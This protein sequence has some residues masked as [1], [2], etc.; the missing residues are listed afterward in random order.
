MNL[1]SKILAILSR[2]TPPPNLAQMSTQIHTEY[3]G[4]QQEP[5]TFKQIKENRLHFYQTDSGNYT[6]LALNFV[7]LLIETFTIHVPGLLLTINNCVYGHLFLSC[8]HTW[9]DQRPCSRD[10][11]RETATTWHSRRVHSLGKTFSRTVQRWAL[12]LCRLCVLGLYHCFNN[13]QLF[14]L[15]SLLLPVPPT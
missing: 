2:Y 14:I 1:W 7:V 4:P 6:C 3:K 5:T 8:K 11:L 12:V 9:W 10:F 15:C 13:V